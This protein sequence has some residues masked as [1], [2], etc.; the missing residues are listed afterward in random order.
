M[1]KVLNVSF[2]KFQQSI[3]NV[4]SFNI[5]ALFFNTHLS[6][7]SNLKKEIKEKNSVFI[8]INVI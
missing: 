5:Y 6:E 2:L 8:K 4:R 3:I 7:I 1:K